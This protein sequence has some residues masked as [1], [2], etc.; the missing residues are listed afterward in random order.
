MHTRDTYGA[1][2]DRGRA[3]VISQIPLF[4]AGAAHRN[5]LGVNPLSSAPV[6]IDAVESIKPIVAVMTT[7]LAPLSLPSSLLFLRL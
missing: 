7:D 1:S 3:S 2:N 6:S 4:D 5:L